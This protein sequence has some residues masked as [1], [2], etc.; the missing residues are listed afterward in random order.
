MFGIRG[1]LTK[2]VASKGWRYGDTSVLQSISNAR[3]QQWPPPAAW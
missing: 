2:M 3:H 1:N